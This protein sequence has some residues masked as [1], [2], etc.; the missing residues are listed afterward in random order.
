M[1]SLDELRNR[2]HRALAAFIR[3]DAAPVLDLWSSSDDTTLANPFGP[4]VRGLEAVREAGERAASQVSDGEAFAVENISTHSTSDLAY[5][6]DIH[7]FTARMPG[8]D[9]PAPVSLR[10]TT[11]YRREDDGWRVAHRHADPLPLQE[12]TAP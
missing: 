11:V 5:D 4:P 7:R 12:P 10:V 1:T 2:Y 8:A 9:E 3:G 6:V